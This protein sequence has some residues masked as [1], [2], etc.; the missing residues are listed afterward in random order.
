MI[1][2]IKII[3]W[4]TR[5]ILEEFCLLI[6]EQGRKAFNEKPQALKR[7]YFHS[8]AQVMHDCVMRVNL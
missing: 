4:V 1:A 5:W 6:E 3:F 8:R 7:H 2:L